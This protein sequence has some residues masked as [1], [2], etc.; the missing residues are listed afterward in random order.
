M[1]KSSNAAVILFLLGFEE[2]AELMSLVAV[3]EGADVVGASTVAAGRGSAAEK[4]NFS[5][6]MVSRK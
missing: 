1:N 4:S 5:I 2:D 3:V 6:Y